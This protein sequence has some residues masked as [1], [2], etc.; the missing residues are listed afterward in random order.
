MVNDTPHANGRDRSQ[1][2][3]LK[4]ITRWFASGSIIAVN[5]RV[6]GGKYT[7]AELY[8]TLS[9]LKSNRVVKRT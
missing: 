1:A 7:V 8:D 9:A 2:V 5:L 3:C 4:C 6:R